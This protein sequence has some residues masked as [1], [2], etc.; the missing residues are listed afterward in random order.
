MVSK[1]S[2]PESEI[3]QRIRAVEAANAK[4]FRDLL[5]AGGFDLEVD[6]RYQN[7]SGLSFAGEDLRG[8]DFTGAN[9]VGCDFK[10]ALTEGARFEKARLST[11]LSADVDSLKSAADWKGH[12]KNWKLNDRNRP[13]HGGE[14]HLPSWSIYFDSPL[15]PQMLVMPTAL[16]CE[17]HPD[18][19]RLAIGMTDVLLGEAEAAVGAGCSIKSLEEDGPRGNALLEWQDAQTYLTWVNTHS[20]CQYRFLYTDEWDAIRDWWL[21]ENVLDTLFSLEELPFWCYD[22]SNQGGALAYREVPSREISLASANIRLVRVLSHPQI[23]GLK[24]GAEE[25]RTE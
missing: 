22:G 13:A 8:I 11:L 12:V 4:S 15:L 18:G 3:I 17:A 25:W 23:L 6:L 14:D 9:I 1:V 5:Q 24:R 7:L 21:D 20:G 16:E 19:T 10:G 2:R